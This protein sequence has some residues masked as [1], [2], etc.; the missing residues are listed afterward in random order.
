MPA[1]RAALLRRLVALA[2]PYGATVM[3]HDDIAAA[4]A[5]AAGGVHLPRGASPIAARRGL[6]A[7]GAHRLLDPRRAGDRG[8]GRA[9]ITRR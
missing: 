1:S 2:Q 3:V 5:A 7:G 6:G 9:P 4:M 8:C